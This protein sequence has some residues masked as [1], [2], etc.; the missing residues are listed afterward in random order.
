MASIAKRLS[1]QSPIERHSGGTGNYLYP[2]GWA[3]PVE[4]A[5]S[6]RKYTHAV[7]II[8][9]NRRYKYGYNL[10]STLYLGLTVQT[11][12]PQTS[13]NS[14]S[15]VHTN[16]KVISLRVDSGRSFMTSLRFRTGRMTL[17]HSQLGSKL[18]ERK[19]DLVIPARCAPRTFSLM[20]PTGVLPYKSHPARRMINLHGSP[21]CD[22]ASDG[23]RRG[24]ASACQQAHKGQDHAHTGARPILLD[25]SCRQVKLDDQYRQI[26]ATG[27]HVKVRAP[28]DVLTAMTDAE[29]FCVTL[30]PGQAELG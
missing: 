24:D 15:T 12:L 1:R 10:A 18:N 7:F 30:D 3:G 28:Q 8:Y 20:P 16:A 17:T 25:C 2:S 14:S 6:E 26:I 21:E 4:Q 27:T 19:T 13:S 29:R 23:Q 22:L 5:R 9:Y 11:S